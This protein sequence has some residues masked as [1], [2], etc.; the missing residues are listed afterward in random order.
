MPVAFMILIITALIS[1]VLELMGTST[2]VQEYTSNDKNEQKRYPSYATSK[3][4]LAG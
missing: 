4:R 2:G 3:Y 1:E